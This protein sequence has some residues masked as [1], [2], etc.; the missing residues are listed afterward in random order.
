MSRNLDIAQSYS[1]DEY[2]MTTPCSWLTRMRR[3]AAVWGIATLVCEAAVT[4][5]IALQ[6]TLPHAVR[7]ALVL[8]TRLTLLG[9]LGALVRM[10]NHM[11]E[12]QKRI[13]LESVFIAFVGSLALVFVFTGLGEADVWQPR[14]DLIAAA[15]M[16]MWAVSY[17]YSSWKYR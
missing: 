12:L 15:M 9:F 17:A 2:I 10:L 4:W 5:T 11:D 8:A 14:W 3:P 13:A 7:Q 6:P 16:A 1:Y